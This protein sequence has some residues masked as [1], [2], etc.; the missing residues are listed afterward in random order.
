MKTYQ[1]QIAEGIAKLQLKDPQKGPLKEIRDI[2]NMTKSKM[3]SN[4]ALHSANNNSTAMVRGLSA[5]KK[6]KCNEDN[7]KEGNQNIPHPNEQ[8]NEKRNSMPSNNTA[9]APAKKNLVIHIPETT[10][11]SQQAKAFQF[12]SLST[13]HANGNPSTTEA[14]GTQI[15]LQPATS[16]TIPNHEPA[17]CSLKRSGVVRAYA[18]STNQGLVR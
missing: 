11:K 12:K 1:R 15:P 7:L 17:K 4:N 5:N 16:I 6:L 3:P 8:P 2:M 18:A 14:K 9:C 10:P 13:K